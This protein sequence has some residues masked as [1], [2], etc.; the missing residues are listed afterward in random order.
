[1]KE[2]DTARYKYKIPTEL[3]R[4]VVKIVGIPENMD[5]IAIGE[6]KK[7]EKIYYFLAYRTPKNTIR[8]KAVSNSIYFS[9]AS[10]V[11]LLSGHDDDIETLIKET[12]VRLSE[13][14]TKLLIQELLKHAYMQ[15]YRDVLL[16]AYGLSH[17]LL[18]KLDTLTEKWK[19]EDLTRK[20][21]EV[22]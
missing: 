14:T 11:A 6:R 20:K 15:Q 21:I 3:K 13:K 17:Y 1:M 22:K 12:V 8:R 19:T 18:K 10:R 9:I 2:K 4:E 16:I 7:G 5:P